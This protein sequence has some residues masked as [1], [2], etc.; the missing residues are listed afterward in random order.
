MTG[1]LAAS[2]QAPHLPILLV[3]GLAVVFG[4][5][6]ARLFQK[7]RIPQV[8]GYIVIGIAVGRPTGQDSV[9]VAARGPE[10]RRKLPL[11]REK[12]E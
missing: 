8:V 2:Q 11:G 10:S 6:G 4:T 9:S 1:W 3:I 5:V 12:K 7:L